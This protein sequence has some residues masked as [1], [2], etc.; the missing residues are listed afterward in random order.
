MTA[1]D[2]YLA[3][4]SA[5]QSTPLASSTQTTR[6]RYVIRIRVTSVYRKTLMLRRNSLP[7]PAATTNPTTIVVRMITSQR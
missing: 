7:R 3:L 1:L 2:S 4:L 5:R 6:S